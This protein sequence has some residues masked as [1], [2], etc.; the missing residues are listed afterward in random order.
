M[1]SVDEIIREVSALKV[2]SEQLSVMFSS[3][4]QSLQQSTTSIAS[5][6]GQRSRSGQ[7]AVASLGAASKSLLDAAASITTLGR[8]CDECVTQLSK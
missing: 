6:V 7:E 4:G 5:I 1:A 3:A 8:T 2:T